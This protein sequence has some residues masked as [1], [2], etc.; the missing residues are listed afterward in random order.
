MTV[1]RIFS[2]H[3]VVAINLTWKQGNYAGLSESNVEKNSIPTILPGLATDDCVIK[4][5]NYLL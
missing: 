5:I 3:L 2:F 1:G 4:H